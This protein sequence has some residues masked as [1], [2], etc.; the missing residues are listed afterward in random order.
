MGKPRRNAGISSGSAIFYNINSKVNLDLEMFTFDPMISIT[1]IF[2]RKQMSPAS[3]KKNRPI[4]FRC[5]LGNYVKVT[6]RQ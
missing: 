2:Q 6:K 1:C 3:N 5:D 4:M